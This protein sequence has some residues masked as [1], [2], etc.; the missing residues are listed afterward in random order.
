MRRVRSFLGV[1]VDA[2]VVGDVVVVDAMTLSL[3]SVDAKVL[4]TS[5]NMDEKDARLTAPFR[6]RATK[7]RSEGANDM[8]DLE[9]SPD[10]V[11][12]RQQRESE[13]FIC[14]Y[15]RCFLVRSSIKCYSS[16]RQGNEMEWIN[17]KDAVLPYV[18]AVKV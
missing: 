5:A 9:K 15:L 11:S 18:V 12:M 16:S 1:D 2:V 10:T 4:V 7:E 14:L 6:C 8:H 13:T 3:L 17:K